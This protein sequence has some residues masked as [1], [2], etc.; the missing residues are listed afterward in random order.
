MMIL[1]QSSIDPVRQEL[2]DL[3]RRK[4]ETLNR[5]MFLDRDGVLRHDFGYVGSKK[6]LDSSSQLSA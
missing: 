1:V 4:S 5:A 2:Q 3:H 6:I